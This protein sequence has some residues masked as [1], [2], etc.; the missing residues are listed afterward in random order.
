MRPIINKAKAY[1]LEQVK[2]RADFRNVFMMIETDEHE[3][4][5]LVRDK[6]KI[7]KGQEKMDEILM[8]NKMN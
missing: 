8:Y 3:M 1:D 5:R 2:R 6:L 7:Q 4:E